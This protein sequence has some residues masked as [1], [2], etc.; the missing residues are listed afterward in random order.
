MTALESAMA[1]D[2]P[3]TTDTP[4][5]PRRAASVRSAADDRPA[6]SS[7]LDW[8][9]AL[10][11]LLVRGPVGAGRPPSPIDSQADPRLRHAQ[12]LAVA[13]TLAT[14]LVHDFNNALLVAEACLE[15]IAEA[16]EQ[17]TLVKDQA[18]AASEALRRASD[19]AQRL[20]TFARP[21]DGSRREVDLTGI[22]R[23]SVRLIEPV[24]RPLVEVSMS[25]PP[26]AL[27]V[28]VD[29]AQI[30]QAILNLCLN[31]RDAMPDG[32]TLHITARSA[33]RWVPRGEKAGRIPVTYALVEVSD[34]GAGIP[35]HLQARV[36]EP[37]FTTK[38]PGRGSGLGL[39]MVRDTVAAHDGLIEL[40]SDALGT[41]FRI[42][43]PLC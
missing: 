8:L 16:P 14:G 6:L 26:H 3:G 23:A 7:W 5:R 25:C 2:P 41:A 36:F 40:T 33:I 27:P 19:Q 39:A 22:V 1:G 17:A 13:G 28:H 12:K 11:R 18:Q 9:A 30:E 42:L 4:R 37:F 32:G 38:E 24:S 21:D 29:P 43:L 34:T 35:L 10:A 31:A 15:L 20:V